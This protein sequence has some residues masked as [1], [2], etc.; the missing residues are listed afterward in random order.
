[1]L[2]T[3]S[4][5]ITDVLTG[6]YTNVYSMSKDY[7]LASK[8][9]SLRQER[10][11][12][13]TIL[14]IKQHKHYQHI[15]LGTMSSI[16]T[17]WRKVIEVM[18]LNMPHCCYSLLSWSKDFVSSNKWFVSGMKALKCILL[19]PVMC[20]MGWWLALSECVVCVRVRVCVTLELFY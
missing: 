19:F 20:C 13:Q 5:D 16:H 7:N 12:K 17:G 9:L 18:I 15:Q 14:A 3:H 11:C 6:D 4:Y 1:M 8:F 2:F 10:Y